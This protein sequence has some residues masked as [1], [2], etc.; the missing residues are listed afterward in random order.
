VEL[1]VI[2]VTTVIGGSSRGCSASCAVQRA[3]LSRAREYALEARPGCRALSL[4]YYC[5]N[6]RLTRENPMNLLVIIIAIVAV[7]LLITGGVTSSL[8]FLIWV[9]LALLIIALI[10]FLLRFIT[11]KKSV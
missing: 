4:G 3:R 1:D 8:N 6:I 9:G 7:I 11:G 10:V 2:D 5:T